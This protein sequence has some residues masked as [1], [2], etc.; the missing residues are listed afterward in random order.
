M[1]KLGKALKRLQEAEEEQRSIAVTMDDGD[2]EDCEYV[3]T[4]TRR[5]GLSHSRKS[6]G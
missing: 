3:P 1:R 2:S 4:Q 5:Q 6:P